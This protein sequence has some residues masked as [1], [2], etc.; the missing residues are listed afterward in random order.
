[1]VGF[2]ITLSI[3]NRAATGAGGATSTID[4]VPI[5][6]ESNTLPDVHVMSFLFEP[7]SPTGPHT[8][9]P[10][11]PVG[12]QV[13]RSTPWCMARN[14]HHEGLVQPPSQRQVPSSSSVE[15]PVPAVTWITPC[16]GKLRS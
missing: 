7:V 6:N 5:V 12:V 11:I 4:G 1:M 2:G 13:S 16:W 8:A 10:R 3:A 9:S 14:A 15:P